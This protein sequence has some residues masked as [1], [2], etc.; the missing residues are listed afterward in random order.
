MILLLCLERVVTSLCAWRP[1]YRLAAAH[2][3][4]APSGASRKRAADKSA[5]V[6]GIEPTDGVGDP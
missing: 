3:L 1:G 4:A 2:S 6:G 5:E